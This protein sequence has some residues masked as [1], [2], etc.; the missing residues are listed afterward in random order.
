LKVIFIFHVK[1]RIVETGQDMEDEVCRLD[2]E[3]PPVIKRPR[4]RPRKKK[5]F[6]KKNVTFGKATYVSDLAR[7]KLQ[8]E[9][10]AEEEEQSRHENDQ[11]TLDHVPTT[12]GNAVRE[13]MLVSDHAQIDQSK[14][15]DECCPGEEEKT[16]NENEQ[17]KRRPT[18][19]V[20]DAKV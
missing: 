17:T 6:T 2:E 20:S 15:Q 18:A 13:V 9:C 1:V 16:R 11:S 3:E 4:G 7:S 10:C 14:L 12:S 5:R 8:D 19:E